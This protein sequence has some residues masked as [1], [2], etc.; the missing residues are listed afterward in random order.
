MPFQTDDG[1]ERM[2]QPHSMPLPD[3]VVALFM[4]NLSPNDLY[5]CSQVSRNF[6]GLAVQAI[7]DRYKI[8]CPEQSAQ[9]RLS[10][11]ANTVDSLSAFLVSIHIQK[12][13]YVHFDLGAITSTAMAER[14]FI[15]M[16]R[17]VDR[18]TSV[19]SVRVYWPS[20]RIRIANDGPLTKLVR[21]VQRFLNSVVAK[22]CR[23][24]QVEGFD[25]I[26]QAQKNSAGDRFSPSAMSIQPSTFIIT[27]IFGS[28]KRYISLAKGALKTVFEDAPTSSYPLPPLESML[29]QFE[30]DSIAMFQPPFAQ[31][32]SA[33]LQASP[34]N[35][36]TL[37]FV[38]LPED[39]HEAQSVLGLLAA[40]APNVT[41]IYLT[42]AR[43]GTM[44]TILD[45]ASQFKDL[46]TL[47]VQPRCFRSEADTADMEIHK[48]VFPKLRRIECPPSF[49][50]D[51]LAPGDPT[52][53]RR[54][55]KEGLTGVSQR[56]PVLTSN[57]VVATTYQWKSCTKLEVMAAIDTIARLESSLS[58]SIGSTKNGNCTLHIAFQF[59]DD[60]FAIADALNRYL[61]PAIQNVQ[62][63]IVPGCEESACRVFILELMLPGTRE[64]IREETYDKAILTFLRLSPSINRVILS[65]NELG[66]DLPKETVGGERLERFRTVST[67]LVSV[68]MY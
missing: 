31:W 25:N 46:D 17:L 55:G 19:H 6:N 62:E 10:H 8:W 30:F 60:L 43:S 20:S 21:S 64:E 47:G 33:L 56:L 40:A 7:L 22:G 14:T 38:D 37:S 49:I 58:F 11:A 12:L 9:L 48:L 26:F 45:W 32:M 42:G 16:R 50:S 36:L 41:A 2:G 44:K 67:N 61:A 52:S 53:L 57:G 29:S 15:K 28:A 54:D 65:S 34:A 3:E 66:L 39:P 27:S 63:R 59:D 1:H 23:K 13:S 51:L 24:L 35:E 68:C 18:V 5:R 4:S